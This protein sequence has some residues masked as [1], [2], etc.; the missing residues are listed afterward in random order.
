[1]SKKV[2]ADN[3]KL[4]NTIRAFASDG[5]NERIPEATKNNLDSIFTTLYNYDPDMN[6]FL[7]SFVN[8]LIGPYVTSKIFENPLAPLKRG[9]EYYGSTLEE[10]FVN[11]PKAVHYDPKGDASLQFKRYIPDVRTAFHTRNY[12]DYYP[13]TISYNQLRSAFLSENGLQN[14]IT[15]ISSSPYSAAA[16]DEYL[17]M[18]DMIAKAAEAGE[19]FPVHVD[20]IDDKD[21]VTAVVRTIKEYANNFMINRPYYNSVGVYNFTMPDELSVIG[22]SQFN[23]ANDVEVLASAFNLDY[24][25]Y[26][27]R[28]INVDK[29]NEADDIVCLM[30]DYR[31]FMCYD[32]MPPTVRQQEIA[33]DLAWNYFYHFWKTF[34]ISPFANAVLFTTANPT[35]SS[36][37]VTPT[38]PTATK[39]E[40]VY[41]TAVVSAS[42]YA[43]KSV[44]WS[45]TGDATVDGNG[46]VKIGSN[47]SGTVTVT[48]TSTFNSSVTGKTTIT[49]S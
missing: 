42:G 5:F 38:N 7:Y 14:L 45:V 39:G 17:I 1:M 4:F 33:T 29:F 44:Y 23:A 19:I 32:N 48:A 49:I 3:I 41:C 34:S 25:K 12:Q 10:A 21:G 15:S 8:R 18:T 35:V 40:T 43:P 37:S 16:T 30:C 11:I 13:I 9:A 36:I 2:V 27:G 6:E 26:L 47:A 31:W 24:A 22:T 20:S 46:T 28:R